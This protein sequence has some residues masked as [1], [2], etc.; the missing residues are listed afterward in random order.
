MTPSEIDWLE[1]V[2]EEARKLII[3]IGTGSDLDFAYLRKLLDEDVE[4][5]E[6]TWNVKNLIA[7]L[8]MTKPD[9]LR[10]RITLQNSAIERLTD[11]RRTIVHALANAAAGSAVSPQAN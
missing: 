7:S 4:V 6:A 3:A 2:A 5:T 1:R 11:T 9:V 8:A 10:G